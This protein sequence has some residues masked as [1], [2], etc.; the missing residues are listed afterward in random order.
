MSTPQT[1][2][3]KTIDT[4]T[5]TRST[6]TS[7]TK[8]TTTTRSQRAKTGNAAAGR[9]A[10]E[11][12]D[13]GRGL[14]PIPRIDLR[15]LRTQFD[16][17]LEI[18]DLEKEPD[19]YQRVGAAAIIA[20]PRLIFTD[21]VGVGKSAQMI[22]AIRWLVAAGYIKRVLLVAPNKLMYQWETEFPKWIGDALRVAIVDGTPKQR[23]AKYDAI[24][25]GTDHPLHHV[26][27]VIVSYGTVRTNTIQLKGLKADMLVIEEAS[28]VRNHDAQ[29]TKAL[30]E[31]ASA[32]PRRSAITATAM[33]NNL[34]NYHTIAEI[35]D[36]EVSGSRASFM[37]KY[38]HVDRFPITLRTGRKIYV[39]N[40]VGYHSLDHFKDSLGPMTFGRSVEELEAVGV[41]FPKVL[42][43][44]SGLDRWV[45]L[46][47][48]QRERYEEVERGILDLGPDETKFLDAI[49][50][51]TRLQ[52]I[53]D[54]V[55]LVFPNEVGSAKLDELREL[56][57]GELRGRQVVIFSKYLQFLYGGVMPLLG[58][59]GLSFAQVHGDISGAD[60]ER[61]RLAFQAGDRQIAVITTAGEMGLNLDVTGTMVCCD[62][63]FNEARM[64][65]VYGRIRRRSSTHSTAVIY[66]LLAKDTLEERA[67]ARAEQRGAMLDWLDSP[68]QYDEGSMHDLLSLVNRK[69][70]LLD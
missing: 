51:V 20:T 27:V 26:H 30:R 64:R 8:M 4:A 21:D 58:D 41:K 40:I 29:A 49:Q 65:Q 36:P 24:L 15:W 10:A 61:E 39:E 13:R 22:M 68:D 9:T 47:S 1:T 48:N 46:T 63:I 69:I 6:P 3:Q 34:S 25:R 19:G 66:R 56:L 35:V 38:C 53:A 70:S 32:I 16:C 42:V 31:L 14:P 55:A 5:S 62:M 17:T 59:L 45:D 2:T 57:E 44:E 18:P 54:N 23:Q 52:Q 67:L 50:R 43:G 11:A 60:A 12:P 7:T 28:M 33:Q 37:R